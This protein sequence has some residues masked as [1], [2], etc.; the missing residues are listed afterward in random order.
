M[1]TTYQITLANGESHD[2]VLTASE[3]S[4]RAQEFAKQWAKMRFSE[5]STVIMV[6]V[7]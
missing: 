5:V 7:K 2:L 4:Y 6:E 1:K 3:P